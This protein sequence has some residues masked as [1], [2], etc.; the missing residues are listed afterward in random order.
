MS[1]QL[2][3]SLFSFKFFKKKMRECALLAT[4]QVVK[5]FK[6][7][8]VISIMGLPLWTNQYCFEYI[9]FH[10][11]H[12]LW[13]FMEYWKCI[14][15]S[16]QKVYFFRYSISNFCLEDYSGTLNFICKWNYLDLCNIRANTSTKICRNTIFGWET[17][18]FTFSLFSLL[19]LAIMGFEGI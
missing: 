14:F 13:L 1:L 3:H 7:Y 8:E 4:Y 11:L 6:L 18:W 16:L 15:K 17:V 5:P 2:F 9:S 19:V 12:K 10:K